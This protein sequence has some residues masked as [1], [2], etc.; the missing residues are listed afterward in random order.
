MMKRI[1][2]IEN[3][4]ISVEL[5]EDLHTLAQMRANH[6][7]EFFDIRGNGEWAG[8]NLNAVRVLF[9]IYVAEQRLRPL[10]TRRVAPKEAMPNDRPIQRRMLSSIVE[11]GGVYGADLVELTEDY[12]SVD[13]KLIKAD[14][15]VEENLAELHTYE[16]T[17][18][19]GD[20]EKLR[21]RLIR[22]FDT[23][24]NW[25]DSKSFLFPGIKLP[26]PKETS[27]ASGTDPDSIPCLHSQP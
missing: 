26:L 2:W 13:A 17:G 25:D 4:V 15:S 23:G 3:A 12:C 18:M 10:F 9:C 7:V 21:G 8:V 16:L 6:L 19:V 24:V 11:P 14:L 20:A 22:Y 27:L 5:R 1:R